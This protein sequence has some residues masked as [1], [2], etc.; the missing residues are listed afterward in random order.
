MRAEPNAAKQ[1][2]AEALRETFS[3]NPVSL[4]G[5]LFSCLRIE[6]HSISVKSAAIAG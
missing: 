3:L 2:A 6:G 4:F 5:G 1:P